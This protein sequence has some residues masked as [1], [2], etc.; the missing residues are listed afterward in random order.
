MRQLTMW[1]VVMLGL[2]SAVDARA[3]GVPPPGAPAATV[4]APDFLFG[5]P[6][7]TVGVRGS[8][9][10]A[11]ADSDWFAFVTD[12]L[13]LDKRDFNAAGFAADVGIPFGR[14][15]EAMI[16]VDF[17]QS[18][19][20]SEYRDFVDNNRQPITQL[21]RLRTTSVTGGVKYTLVDRGLEVSRLAWVPRQLVPYVGA[22][23]GALRYDLLQYGDFVDFN[24]S[25]VFGSTFQSAG[26]APVAQAFAGIDV[27][28]LKRIY[29]S[30]DARY[31]WAKATLGRD[32][33]DF[34][35]IDLAGFKLAAGANFLF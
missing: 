18:S 24:D 19:T 5:R 31:Q 3:Q 15:A 21:T 17:N 11:R 23:G 33:I 9:L 28:V 2:A 34:E 12:Q 30:F 10:F 16:G 1:T 27:R 26:W 8:W 32:W 13:S 29:V 35:P 22:G 14:R 7:A 25:S 6:H 4:G 20:P